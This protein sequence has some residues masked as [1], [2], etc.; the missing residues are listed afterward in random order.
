MAA[1]LRPI[2][3]DSPQFEIME[4]TEIP[5]LGDVTDIPFEEGGGVEEVAAQPD[6]R[7]G[8]GVVFHT[9]SDGGLSVKKVVPNGPA[10]NTRAI[11][12]GDVLTLIDGRDVYRWSVAQIYDLVM[13]PPGTTVELGFKRSFF[14]S[15]RVVRH[16]YMLSIYLDVIKYPIICDMLSIY[17]DVIEYPII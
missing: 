6:R 16:E 17:L 5:D 4:V 15:Y 8:I 9:N 3:T 13:G 11:E 12:R 14:K 7:A 10:A 2:V 1:P